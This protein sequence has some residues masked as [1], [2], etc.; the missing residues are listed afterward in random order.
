MKFSKNPFKAEKRNK[1]LANM[2]EQLVGTDWE[3]AKD[4]VGLIFDLAQRYAKKYGEDLYDVIIQEIFLFIPNIC[5]NYRPDMGEFKQFFSSSIAFRA[6]TIL[7]GFR[8][9]VET[10]EFS[11]ILKYEDFDG[12]DCQ[13]DV[14]AAIE[15]LPK[16]ER[17][18]IKQKFYHGKTNQEIAEL[19]SAKRPWHKRVGRSTIQRIYAVA[20]NKLRDLLSDD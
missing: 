16:L 11:D 19:V 4:H 7:K 6:R 8:K 3:L 17:Y 15:K 1:I 12:L 10:Q 13:A 5:R 2:A 20:L 9:R 14:R 18:I